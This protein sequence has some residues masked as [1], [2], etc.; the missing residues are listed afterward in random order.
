MAFHCGAAPGIIAGGAPGSGK[1]PGTGAEATATGSARD[2]TA[3][4]GV[5]TCSAVAE[6]APA[7]RASVASLGGGAS[8]AAFGFPARRSDLA[9]SP[10]AASAA[11]AASACNAEAGSELN[12]PNAPEGAA[13]AGAMEA[14]GGDML[15]SRATGGRVSV[16]SAGRMLTRGSGFGIESRS[17]GSTR[18]ARANARERAGSDARDETL[19]KMLRRDSVR[20]GGK[21]AVAVRRLVRAAAPRHLQ[22]VKRDKSP[23]LHVPAH[24]KSSGILPRS[25]VPTG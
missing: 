2:G 1:G 10:S 6:G 12:A 24:E 23:G 14:G 22:N 11:L 3:A 13:G 17:D 16:M 8:E 19:A 15:R 9:S 21:P 5:V 20:R 18:G 7:G 25:R 4:S